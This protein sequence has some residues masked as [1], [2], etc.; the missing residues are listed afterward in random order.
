M[1]ASANCVT[2]TP[3]YQKEGGVQEENESTEVRAFEKNRKK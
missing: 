2:I 3:N 1:G